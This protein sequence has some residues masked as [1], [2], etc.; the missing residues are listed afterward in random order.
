MKH[1]G[2]IQ[3]AKDTANSAR[4]IHSP[5]SAKSGKLLVS[6]LFPEYLITPFLLAQKPSSLMEVSVLE[7]VRVTKSYTPLKN[8]NRK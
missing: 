4:V 7:A 1:Q 8:P 3:I 5:V 6:Y 2:R